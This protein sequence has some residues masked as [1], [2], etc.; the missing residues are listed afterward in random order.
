MEFI[1]LGVGRQLFLRIDD[2]YFSLSTAI[3]FYLLGGAITSSSRRERQ[4]PSSARSGC[5]A[6]SVEKV[7]G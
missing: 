6:A 2:N 3:T 5:R 7:P 1:T 4:T